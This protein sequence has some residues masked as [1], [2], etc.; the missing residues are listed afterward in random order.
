MFCTALLCKSSLFVTLF[1]KRPIYEC[2]EAVFNPISTEQMTLRS[3]HCYRSVKQFALNSIVGCACGG[4][5]I[6]STRAATPLRLQRS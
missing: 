6:T 2:S 1:A 4:I 5:R 3:I